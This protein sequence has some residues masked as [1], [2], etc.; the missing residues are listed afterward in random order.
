MNKSPAMTALPT[1]RAIL[2]LASLLGTKESP[3]WTTLPTKPP[4]LAAS[5]TFFKG[6]SARSREARLPLSATFEI[7]PRCNLRC[8]HCYLGTATGGHCSVGAQA[9]ANGPEMNTAEACSVLDKIAAAGCLSVLMTG[10]EVMLRRDFPQLYRHARKIG[11]AVRVFTNGTMITDHILELFRELPPLEVEISLYGST[12]EMYQEVTGSERGFQRCREGITRLLAI[13][14]RVKLKTVVMRQT[15]AGLAEM[16]AYA[17]SLGVPFRFDTVVMP[18]L[19]GNRDP[20]AFR[21]SPAE[22]VAVERE[23]RPRPMVPMPVA[24]TSPPG[25][26]SLFA[27]GAARMSFMVDGVGEMRPCMLLQGKRYDLLHGTFDEGWRV[28][29][30]LCQMKEEEGSP[31]R[32]CVDKPVCRKCPALFEMETGNI[33]K[34]PAWLCEL[35]RLR[36][37][38]LKT[39]K[40]TVYEPTTC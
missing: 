25:G 18:T 34:P 30:P 33:N 19:G 15:R 11:L 38:A 17:E 9:G 37:L 22:A 8:V 5:E 24:T 3:P 20:L 23:F 14:V 16:K 13:G 2:P 10:G 6:L 27:C 31:C 29:E 26:D 32:G 35:A 12:P 36:S 28:M 4:V 1:E 7:S 40:P 39:A 21:L